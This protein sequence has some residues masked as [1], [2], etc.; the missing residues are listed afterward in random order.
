MTLSHPLS[1][2]ISH[3][4]FLFIFWSY[5]LLSMFR[6]QMVLREMMTHRQTKRGKQSWSCWR[7]SWRKKTGS[8]RT[9]RSSLPPKTLLLRPRSRSYPS[10]KRQSRLCRRSWRE[11]PIWLHSFRRNRKRRAPLQRLVVFMI[12]FLEIF[13]RFFLL[14]QYL[15]HKRKK[16]P[17]RNYM[18]QKSF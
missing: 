2:L 18:H 11:T 7:G 6:N 3:I 1:P 12:F 16:K 14:L 8:S 5:D 15:I 10:R 13:F 9:R 4:Y 17:C